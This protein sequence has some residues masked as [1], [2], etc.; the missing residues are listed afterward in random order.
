[1]V[2]VMGE[3]L[4]RSGRRTARGKGGEQRKGEVER[5]GFFPLLSPFP[6]PT[7]LSLNHKG[8]ADSPENKDEP[9]LDH[10]EK[11]QPI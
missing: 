4:E 2:E 8:S 7:I 9:K 1:M 11:W 3:S 10:Q 5:G 6:Y